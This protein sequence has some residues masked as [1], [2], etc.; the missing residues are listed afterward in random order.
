ML[1]TTFAAIAAGGVLLFAAL[2]GIAG[3]LPATSGSEPPVARVAIEIAGDRVAEKRL[4]EIAENL[5]YLE[6]SRP[7][8]PELLQD[9]I[10]A[11]ILCKKFSSIDVETEEVA[12]GLVVKFSLVAFRHVKRIDISGEDPVFERKIR[13]MMTIYTGDAFVEK[14]VREQAVLLADALEDL[15][16]D[17]REVIVL[18]HLQELSFSEVA[19][20]MGRSEDSVKKTWARALAAR[21]PLV[22]IL[23]D[24]LLAFLLCLKIKNY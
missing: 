11:L 4:R 17:Y 2:S 13:S 5:I 19:R 22:L 24:L 15:P 3:D 18:R 10:E 14:T 6:P 8:S 9:S 21:R 23:E 16:A 7:F 20:R 12:D 1:K